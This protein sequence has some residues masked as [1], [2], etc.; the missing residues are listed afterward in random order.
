M[1]LMIRT[2][3]DELINSTFKQRFVR[4]DKHGEE[5][6]NLASALQKSIVYSCFQFHIQRGSDVQAAIYWLGRMF[7]GGED[8]L[9]IARR[10]LVI[11]SEDVGLADPY[12]LTLASACFQACKDI[13]VPEC[14]LALTE[15]ASYLALTSKSNEVALAYNRAH[16][17]VHKDINPPV[18]LHIR[19]APM[20]GLGYGIG[21]QYGYNKN[22]TYLPPELLDKRF[23]DVSRA[24][25]DVRSISIEKYIENSKRRKQDE[26]MFFFYLFWKCLL[27]SFFLRSFTSSIFNEISLYDCR[28]EFILLDTLLLVLLLL[29]TFGTEEE[30]QEFEVNIDNKPFVVFILK[31]IYKVE[32]RQSYTDGKNQEVR[33][34]NCVE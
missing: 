20:E 24:V 4:Y 30:Q 21:Y 8:P 25:T 34:K 26:Q 31:S 13:G 15:C 32:T 12:A 10:L 14:N 22:Q 3:T 28:E 6:Y 33:S 5:H 23:M 9:F 29:I 17:L 19:N 11:A 27:T 16:D 1:R 18:P 7:E 2:I